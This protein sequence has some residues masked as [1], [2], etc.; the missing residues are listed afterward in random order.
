MGGS[1]GVVISKCWTASYPVRIKFSE[2]AY[3]SFTENGRLYDWHKEPSLKLINKAKKSVKK[4]KVAF[5]MFN[6][7]RWNISCDYYS[8]LEEFKEENPSYR[9]AACEIIKASEKEFVE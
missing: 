2:N 1:E 6:I 3:I 4:Y 5:S 7:Q 9:S 8:S